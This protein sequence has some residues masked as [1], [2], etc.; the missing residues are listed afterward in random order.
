MKKTFV[1][2]VIL[3]AG[4]TAAMADITKSYLFWRDATLRVV[5]EEADRQSVAPETLAI[6][7]L[8][9]RRSC[10]AG[11]IGMVR[12]YDIG[13]QDLQRQLVSEHEKLRH[14]ALHDPLTGLANR[15]LLLGRLEHALEQADRYPEPVAVLYLDLDGFKEINDSQ[16][17]DVGDQVLIE[18][19]RRLLGLVR[20][21]DTV[22]RLGGDE[23]VILC[24][25]MP[26]GQPELTALADRVRAV[27]ADPMP[28]CPGSRVSVTVGAVLSEPGSDRDAT[29]RAADKAMYAAKHARDALGQAR[30]SSS[31]RL[32][33]AT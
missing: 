23:F 2:G 30:T 19:A 26:G 11:L 13:R 17:H 6:A 22:A 32:A 5:R 10:D 14:L 24:E 20:S 15:M 21:S 25:R 1:I 7:E 28:P 12:Q 29:L 9:V 18:V 8:V 27:V 16:G 31:S 4:A 33:Q 3:S